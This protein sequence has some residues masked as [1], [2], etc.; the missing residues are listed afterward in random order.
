MSFVRIAVKLG[1]KTIQ[2]SVILAKD[3]TFQQLIDESKPENA[4]DTPIV[5][6]AAAG[7]PPFMHHQFTNIADYSFDISFLCS[8][9]KV[10][11]VEIMFEQASPTNIDDNNQNGMEIEEL[12]AS[13]FQHIKHIDPTMEL[14]HTTKKSWKNHP[15][16]NTYLDAHVIDSKYMYQIKKCNSREC[17][18]K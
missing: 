2:D 18:S 17:C 14:S 13:M 8:Q 12:M 6:R 11:Y 5:V 7:A 15:E 1:K 9:V 4:A 3:K 10:N 16:L